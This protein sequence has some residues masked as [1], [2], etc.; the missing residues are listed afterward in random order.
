MKNE[1]EVFR[2]REGREQ[3]S[4]KKKKK[5]REFQTERIIWLQISINAT[6]YQIRPPMGANAKNPTCLAWDRGS[7]VSILDPGSIHLAAMLD[8]SFILTTSAIYL[9]SVVPACLLGLTL[10]KVT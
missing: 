4:K 1:L 3:K 2:R 8:G 7:V 5:E 6:S 10:A 9:I